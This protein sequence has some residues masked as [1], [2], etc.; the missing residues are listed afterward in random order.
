VDLW[1]ELG[2]ELAAYKVSSERTGPGDL[3]FGTSTGKPDGRQNVTKRL[4]RAIRRSN[5]QGASIQENLTMHSLRRT[6]A[7]LL[8][9]RGEDPRYV[10][11][12]IG[13]ADPKLAL[14]IYAKV[15]GDRNR[16]GRGERLVGVL[17]GVS[18]ALPGTERPNGA[19]GAKVTGMPS[20][21]KTVR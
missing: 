4:K 20:N 5:E 14:R 8:Y 17:G 21:D 12:Q 9:L 15:V 1:P 6:F 10:M 7:S 16:R 18:W 2:D 3:V 19:R 11:D 13:H